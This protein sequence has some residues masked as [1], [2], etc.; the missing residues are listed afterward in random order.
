[1]TS[2]SIT[3]RLTAHLTPRRRRWMMT[4]TYFRE[5]SCRTLNW[6]VRWLSIRVRLLARRRMI[7]TTPPPECQRR[8]HLPTQST[9]ALAM[10]S[11]QETHATRLSLEEYFIGIDVFFFI[12]RLYFR[13]YSLYFSLFE[14]LY[15][16][17]FIYDLKLRFYYL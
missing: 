14:T 9:S 3:L 8:K 12:Y 4:L 5:M 15:F 7:P 1:L 17:F 2:L 13:N 16:I 10:K 11:D 6:W